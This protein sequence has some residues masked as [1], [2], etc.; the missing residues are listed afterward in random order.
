M[1]IDIIQIEFRLFKKMNS[2]K[3]LWRKGWIFG[4]MHDRLRA[5]CMKC[6]MN[7]KMTVSLVRNFRHVNEHSGSYIADARN[8][9]SFVDLH[10]RF[11]VGIG[12]T[13]SMKARQR[14]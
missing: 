13:I 9:Q 11:E 14:V 6:N 7:T 3:M 8:V 12:T 1:R 10:S 2:S 5:R 4:N